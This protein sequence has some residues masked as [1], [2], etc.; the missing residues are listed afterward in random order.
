MT[1]TLWTSDFSIEGGRVK[2]RTTGAELALDRGLLT[3]AVLWLGYYVPVRLKSL[4]TTL[5]RPGPRVWFAPHTPRPWYLVWLAARWGG[6][7]F[8]RTAA[9]ADAAFCFEDVT[10]GRPPA[11][12]AARRFNFDC[13]D[14]SKSHVA[15]VFEEVFGYPLTVDP[16]QWRGPAVEKGEGNGAHDGRLVQCPCPAAPGRVYQRVVDTVEGGQ[17]VDLRT[18][19]VAGKPALVFVK[20]RPVQDR[21]ANYNSSVSLKTPAE[22]FSPEE[23]ATIER[24]CGAMHLD[25]GGLDILRDRADGR[26]YVVDVN[27]T[28]MPPLRLPWLQKMDAIA[29]LSRAFLLMINGESARGRE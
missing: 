22:T 25:W 18:P 28:D 6:V 23:L 9:E 17:V 7:R 4:W 19:C 12:A 1:G 13:M 3:D 21:F 5:T 10:V 24:F 14:V 8:A 2:V 29:R 11:C 16:T 20:R 26:L 27:K 15:R